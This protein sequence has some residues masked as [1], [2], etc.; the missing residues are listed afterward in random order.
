MNLID[1]AERRWLPDGVVR[2]GMRRLVA[3][4]LKT[5]A[6]GDAAEIAERQLRF[7]D[8]LAASP[9]AIETQAA[10]RQ[11]YEVPAEFFKLH[12]GPRLKYSS[13]LY[14]TG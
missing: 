11:H 5:E 14:A 12:L 7:V 2:A 8:E 1:L 6:R 10:N 3:K 13:C 9:I 4:R